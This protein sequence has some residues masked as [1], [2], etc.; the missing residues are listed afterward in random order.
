MQLNPCFEIE[1]TVAAPIPAG[2]RGGIGTVCITILDGKVTSLNPEKYPITGTVKGGSDWISSD[3]EN[4]VNYLNVNCVATLPSGAPCHIEYKGVMNLNEKLA[5]V[6]AGQEVDGQYGD[7]EYYVGILA[8]TPSTDP[9]ENWVNKTMFFGR[10]KLQSLG[11][12]PKVFYE[13]YAP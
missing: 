10:G 8:H 11:G 12:T 13:V 1:L 3:Q 5:P 2:G 4:H 7:S 9:K 6:F